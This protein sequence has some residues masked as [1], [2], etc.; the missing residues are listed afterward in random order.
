[1]KKKLSKIISGLVCLCSVLFSASQPA[2]TQILFSENFENKILSTA[3]QPVSGNWHISDV[4]EMRI[5]PAENGYTYV[6][7]ANDES[8][9]RLLVDIA[10]TIKAGQVKLS[11][12]Y[13]TYSKGPGAMIEVEFH[14]K[15]LKDGLKG[16]MSTFHLPVKGRWIEFQKIIKIPAEANWIWIGFSETNPANKVSKTICFDNI[17]LSAVH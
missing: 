17:V 14:K 7:C 10:D 11:F 9:I 13:Y 2:N 5:A 6:L 16:K 15:D 1:M 12:S 8:F 4:Q 3:W